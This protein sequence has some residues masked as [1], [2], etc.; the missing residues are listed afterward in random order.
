[1]PGIHCSETQPA[2]TR[3][4]LA[5]AISHK[6]FVVPFPKQ[7]Y[8][9]LLVF[10]ELQA[11]KG[12][13]LSA[14]R[15]PSHR[16]ACRSLQIH[17]H[18]R[19]LS[20]FCPQ[21]KQRGTAYALTASKPNYH[22]SEWWHKSCQLRGDRTHHHQNQQ[23][24]NLGQ[25]LHQTWP[26]AHDAAVAKWPVSPP[27]GFLAIISALSHLPLLGTSTEA[28]ILNNPHTYEWIPTKQT[29]LL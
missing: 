4:F 12:P 1:M 23:T 14:D 17:L 8:P 7:I 27:V 16:H 15:T 18:T 6:A 28:A 3:W 13:A 11:H 9:T 29:S 22:V 2:Q 26:Q 21:H 20:F 25:H 19:V 24:T 5:D 10:T